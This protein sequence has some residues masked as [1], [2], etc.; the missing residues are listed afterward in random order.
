MKL[1]LPLESINVILQILGVRPY[2]E[3]FTLI[4]EITAQVQPQ[5]NATQKVDKVET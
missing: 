2:Q 4:T 1:E 5:V 3:V